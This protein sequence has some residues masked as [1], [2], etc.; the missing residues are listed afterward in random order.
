MVRPMI[1][2]MAALLGCLVFLFACNNADPEKTQR[3]LT[4]AQTEISSL[5]LEIN[6]LQHRLADLEAEH[7][8]LVAK[9]NE[10]K[11]WSKELISALGP[12]VWT[13]GTY[14]RPIPLQFYKNATMTELVEALNRHFKS[15]QLP[16]FKFTGMEKRTAVV[17][18]EEGQ[19]LAETMGTT[20]AQAYL[21]A[22]TYT[23]C[24]LETVDCV[25]FEF[26]PGTHA[27]P[28]QYCR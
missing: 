27:V 2:R 13:P 22:V 5:R 21:G 18:V 8:N 6:N 14:E 16:L 15:I 20:G 7:E 10:L 23:L 12:S 11:L 19:R 4:A 3:Q 28:G 25:K 1:T 9:H 24:S 17:L 26:T